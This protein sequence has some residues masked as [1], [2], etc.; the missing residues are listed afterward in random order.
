MDRTLVNCNFCSKVKCDRTLI[1]RVP[2]SRKAFVIFGEEGIEIANTIYPC[3]RF[4]RFQVVLIVLIII[5]LDL[6]RIVPVSDIMAMTFVAANEVVKCIQDP[7]KD[8][9]HLYL[10]EEMDLLMPHQ[11]NFVFGQFGYPDEN[12][13][14][15]ACVVIKNP[16]PGIDLKR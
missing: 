5:C 15:Q 13:K 16:F 6:K 9:K 11:T 10:L 2:V 12:E 8:K 14:G 3:E 1:T 4:S 7:V